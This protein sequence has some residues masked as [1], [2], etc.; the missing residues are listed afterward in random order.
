MVDS[1]SSS[2]VSMVSCSFVN[3][4][5]RRVYKF[6]LAEVPEAGQTG[7]SDVL[8]GVSSTEK[9][10]ELPSSPITWRSQFFPSFWS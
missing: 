4:F 7:T 10:S 8:S 6:V 1:S 3:D 5:A 2:P 9:Y